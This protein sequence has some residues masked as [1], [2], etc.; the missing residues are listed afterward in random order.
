MRTLLVGALVANLAGCSHQPS[1]IRAAEDTAQDTSHDMTHD[2]CASR[3]PL[4]CWM[5]I[6]VPLEPTSLT[7]SSKTRSKTSSK[8]SSK[9]S[10]KPSSKTPKRDEIRSNRHRALDAE[11]V[12]G[13][14]H[15]SLM[16]AQ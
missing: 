2:S 6:R 11:D 12:G 1:P 10:S 3:N 13:K 15:S 9:P 7:T 8:T 16:A 4:A 14:R 5:S